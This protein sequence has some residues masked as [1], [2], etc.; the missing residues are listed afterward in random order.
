MDKP[1]RIFIF[2]NSGS[3]KSTL[4]HILS[5]KT[6]ITPAYLDM[7]HWKGDN[8]M[9]DEKIFQRKVKELA[10]SE[11]WIIEGSYKKVAETICPKADIIVLLSLPRFLCVWRIL[12]RLLKYQGKNLP[13]TSENCTAG[14]FFSKRTWEHIK[15]AW[16][17][18]SN[19]EKKFLEIVES[20]G[21][22][23]KLVHL[24][25]NRDVDGFLRGIC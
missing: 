1:K 18:P 21:A 22:K 9:E 25:S 4:T 8:H 19:N 2:G 3:G 24:S 11:E 10:N 23:H 13:F 7:H 12:K 14:R 15:W 17:F 16:Q 5:E 6:G 20:L